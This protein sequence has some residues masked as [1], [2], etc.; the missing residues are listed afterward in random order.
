MVVVAPV[1]NIVLGATELARLQG[2][3]I[4]L[5]KMIMYIAL[6]TLLVLGAVGLAFNK[7]L[8]FINN[9]KLKFDRILLPQIHRDLVE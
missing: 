1:C 8:L 2:G 9:C 6:P 3:I 7:N 4:L 5:R